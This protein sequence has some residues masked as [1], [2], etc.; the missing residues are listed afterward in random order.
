MIPIGMNFRS[1]R[2]LVFRRFL[3]CNYLW[4]WQSTISVNLRVVILFCRLLRVFCLRM[5]PM[6]LIIGMIL[7]KYRNIC[8]AEF[9]KGVK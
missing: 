4:K 1:G 8:C 9:R 7:L 5:R 6:R 3:V 2:Q